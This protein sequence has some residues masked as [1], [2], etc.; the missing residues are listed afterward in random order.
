M[1]Y[2]YCLK[3]FQKKTVFSA[4][5]LHFQKILATLAGILG[6]KKPVS[7]GLEFSLLFD[8]WLKGELGW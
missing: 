6:T 1:F 5:F 8:K 2:T 7:P 4:I 3:Y